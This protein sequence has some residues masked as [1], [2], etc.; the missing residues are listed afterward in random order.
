M[1]GTNGI[2][3]WT[4]GCAEDLQI[5]LGDLSFVIHA[6]VL[7]GALFH[8]LFGQPFYTLWM[9]E[10]PSCCMTLLIHCVPSLSTLSHAI[11]SQLP[12]W[13]LL[14]GQQC[15]PCPAQWPTPPTPHTVT[16]KTFPMFDTFEL[17]TF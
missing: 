8:L 11:H 9:A 12:L 15:L 6:H 13:K 10:C 1:E 5:Q 4:L 17:V 14:C 3:T 2:H 16:Q 7:E